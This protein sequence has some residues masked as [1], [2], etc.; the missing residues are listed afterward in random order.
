[1]CVLTVH[2]GHI[3]YYIVLSTVL[4]IENMLVRICRNAFLSIVAPAKECLGHLTQVILS[5]VAPSNQTFS[6]ENDIIDVVSMEVQWDNVGSKA[7][8]CQHTKS[9]WP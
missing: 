2:Y 8:L 4:Y 3:L 5:L 1:M 9:A 6:R 7:Q